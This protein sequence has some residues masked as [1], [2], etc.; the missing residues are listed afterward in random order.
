MQDLKTLDASLKL[1]VTAHSSDVV[2][3]DLY[4]VVFWDSTSAT[5][6]EQHKTGDLLVQYVM[7]G[8]CLAIGIFSNNTGSQAVLGA[9]QE[10]HPLVYSSK[11]QY[12]KDISL[13]KIYYPYHELMRNVKIWKRVRLVARFYCF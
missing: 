2:A 4:Q 6:S 9:M 8:G 10:Y 5:I 12:P 11:L 3:W 13:G 7:N 1:D